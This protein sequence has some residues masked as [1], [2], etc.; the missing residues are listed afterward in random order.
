MRGD[1]DYE[2]CS[3]L[4]VFL[5]HTQFSSSLAKLCFFASFCFDSTSAAHQNSERSI[6]CEGLC[7]SH[8]FAAVPPEPADRSAEI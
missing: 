3:C 5:K 4:L 8:S 1:C 7:C 6:T 2:A